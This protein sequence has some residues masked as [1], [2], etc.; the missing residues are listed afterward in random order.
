M[1]PCIGEPVSYMRLERYSLRELPA[2]DVQRVAAHL[3]Q[4]ATCRA[5]YE[6]IQA[7]GREQEVAALVAKISAPQPRAAARKRGWLWGAGAI[8]A[9]LAGLL[10]V[11]RSAPGSPPMAPGSIKGGELAL[12]LTRVNGHGQLLDPSRFAQGDRFKLALSCPPALAGQ[13]RVLAFQAGEIFEPL[14]VQTLESC[15][16]RR[17]LTGAFQLDGQAPV[18]VCVVLGEVPVAAARSRAALPDPHVCVR[19]EPVVITP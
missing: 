19:V 7:D 11:M 2:D 18:D 5:C 10:F 4:C 15:G 6:R 16:N 17:A 13:V 9:S 14:P 1:T 12:E 3:S 8:A